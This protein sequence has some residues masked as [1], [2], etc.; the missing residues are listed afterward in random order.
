MRVSIFPHERCTVKFLAT[1]RSYK[2]LRFTSAISHQALSEIISDTRQA[3][4]IVLRK[5]YICMIVSILFC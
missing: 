1:G 4:F 3:T 2:D 5:K